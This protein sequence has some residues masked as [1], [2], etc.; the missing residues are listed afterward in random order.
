[1]IQGASSTCVSQCREVVETRRSSRMR[2]LGFLVVVAVAVGVAGCTPHHIEPVQF[3]LHHAVMMAQQKLT[4]ERKQ[5][6]FLSIQ[7]L[8]ALLGAPDRILSIHEFHLA[9]AKIDPGEAE[10]FQSGLQM[11]LSRYAEGTAV[12]RGQAT[13]SPAD[14]DL[15]ECKVWLYRWD[16][17]DHVELTTVGGAFVLPVVGHI[18]TRLSYVYVVFDSHVIAWT[19]VGR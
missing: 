18:S 9:L 12:R 16:Q 17:P 19:D 4:M 13:S 2:T 7:Q 8:E 5:T 10:S 11:R 3:R 15:D 6:E 14:G 1:M